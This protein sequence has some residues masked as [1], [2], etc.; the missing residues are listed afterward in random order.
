MQGLIQVIEAAAAAPNIFIPEAIR[1]PGRGRGGRRGHVSSK[2][3]P[4]RIHQAGRVDV[5]LHWVGPRALFLKEGGGGGGGGS[6]L[7]HMHMQEWEA[8]KLAAKVDSF[9]PD[10][11]KGSASSLVHGSL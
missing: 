5:V 4:S 2:P 1:P 10:S 3:A 8:G 11:G 7:A 6:V 9:A